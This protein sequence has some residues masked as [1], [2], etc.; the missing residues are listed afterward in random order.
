M[1][2]STNTS[3]IL[4]HIQRDSRFLCGSRIFPNKSSI[5]WTNS[6]TRWGDFALYQ[7]TS[8]PIIWYIFWNFMMLHLSWQQFY[9]GFHD[10][11]LDVRSSSSQRKR[12]CNV[13]SQD[14]YLSTIESHHPF[15]SVISVS[16]YRVP[17][18]R[19]KR[20]K[21]FNQ[22]QGAHAI[23]TSINNGTRTSK[24]GMDQG[25]CWLPQV[26]RNCLG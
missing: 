2:H 9:D 17:V 18:L 20:L 16:G 14:F 12:I 6:F 25:T 7:F 8:L 15:A 11:F 4:Q 1:S 21:R 22:G 10:Y 3:A 5:V 26:A 23:E 19:P 24:A 13:A